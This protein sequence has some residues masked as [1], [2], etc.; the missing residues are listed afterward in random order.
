MLLFSAWGNSRGPCRDQ[1][2]SGP[3]APDMTPA[4]PPSRFL[5]GIVGVSVPCQE[6]GMWVA[7]EWGGGNALSLFAWER[8][9]GY[10]E[11]S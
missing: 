4:D 5:G 7:L 9:R 8:G 3:H 6:V 11:D 1:A 2:P 10:P